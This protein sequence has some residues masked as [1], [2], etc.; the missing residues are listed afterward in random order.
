MVKF[1]KR[2]MKMFQLNLL[3]LILLF[4]VVGLALFLPSFLIQNLWNLTLADHLERDLRIDILQA[5]LLWGALLSLLYMSG[6]FKF[7]LDFQKLENI[8]LESID[9]PELR[10]EIENLRLKALDEKIKKIEKK[11]KKREKKS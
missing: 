9:D 5:S 6:I 11:N 7:K 3:S 2:Q 10:Q 8:D 4:L 1:I